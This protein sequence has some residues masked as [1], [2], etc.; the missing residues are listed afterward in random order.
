MSGAQPESDI[1]AEDIFEPVVLEKYDPTIIKYLLKLR[2]AGVPPVRDI[3]IEDLRSNP[4][5]FAPPWWKDPTGWERVADG[6]V[7]VRDGAKIPV[8]IYHPDPNKFGKGPYGLHLNFHGGG[9]VLGDLGTESQLCASMRDNAGVVVIDVNYRHCPEVV[10]GVGVDDAWRAVL[11]ARESASS[12]NINP[13]SISI[14]GI[15]AGAH[16]SIILQ[17]VARDANVP[18]KLCLATVPVSSDA[19]LYKEY[20]ESPFDS[21]HE[22]ANGP[23]LSWERMKFFGPLCFPEDRVE[24]IC[25]M[26][27]EWWIAPIKSKNWAGL[28][29]TFIRTAECDPLRDEGEAYALKLA[30]GG[31]KVTLKRYLKS[32]HT[33]MYFDWFERK[34]EYDLDSITA[35]KQA[36]GIP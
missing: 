2:A 21:F 32:P 7:T 4:A 8:K 11:W 6:E 20:T 24:E 17:H 28:C 15:S 19:L 5:K 31:N 23:I 34:R 26:W 9:F 18:L 35:L 1:K 14:G 25:A 16:I 13:S 27:P 33:F 10:W 22:F 36:H 12:L 29:D 30:Q 3:R